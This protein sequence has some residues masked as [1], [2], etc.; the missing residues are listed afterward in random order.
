MTL[1]KKREFGSLSI[2]EIIE[3]RIR[4]PIWAAGFF[5]VHLPPS[6][7]A[8]GVM[9][10]ALFLAVYQAALIVYLILY[11]MLLSISERGYMNEQKRLFLTLH[12]FCTLRMYIEFWREMRRRHSDICGNSVPDKAH[13][14]LPVRRNPRR[15]RQA[16]SRS[17]FVTKKDGSPSFS[18]K[19]RMY[20]ILREKCSGGARRLRE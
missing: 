10:R 20:K 1:L 6:Q 3:K 9:R 18:K 16:S 7:A 11:L 8:Q 4:P 2:I 5:S 15:P 14:F 17:T 19:I 13:R 12:F